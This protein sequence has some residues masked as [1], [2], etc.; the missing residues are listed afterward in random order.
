MRTGRAPTSVTNK[1]SDAAVDL[2]RRV[3]K[4]ESY[5]VVE[6]PAKVSK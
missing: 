2:L 3:A 1:Y 5:Q 6:G 4:G